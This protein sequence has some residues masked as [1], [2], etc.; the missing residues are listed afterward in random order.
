MENLFWRRAG[1]AKFDPFFSTS[2][3]VYKKE[4]L[5]LELEI[6]GNI[7]TIEIEDNFMTYIIS[8]KPQTLLNSTN[9]ILRNE[10]LGQVEIDFTQF[11]KNTWSELYLLT[12]YF[13]KI[14]LIL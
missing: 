8:K 10:L 14:N 6:D 4:E 11:S 12:Y 7:K 1:L 3:E 5:M 13:K 9:V 2:F